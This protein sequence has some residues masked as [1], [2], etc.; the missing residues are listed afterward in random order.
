MTE[1]VEAAWL[2]HFAE[3]AGGELETGRFIVSEGAG[4]NYR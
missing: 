2:I 1:K 4:A 3:Q